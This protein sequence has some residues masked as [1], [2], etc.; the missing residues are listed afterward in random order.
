MKVSHIFIAASL[1]LCASACSSD[2]P[3]GSSDGETPGGN[4]GSNP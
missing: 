3:K 1:L 4:G 2:E